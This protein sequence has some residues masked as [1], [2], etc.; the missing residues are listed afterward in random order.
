MDKMVG[1]MVLFQVFQFSPLSTNPLMF[2]IHFRS[3]SAI[4]RRKND[5][6]GN[7]EEKVALQ[8]VGKY[9]T[10]KCSGSSNGSTK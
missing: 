5:L 2:Y 9:C 1:N 10:G 4:I 3:S 8:D 6:F 7:A